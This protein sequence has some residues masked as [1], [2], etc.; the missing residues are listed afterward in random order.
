MICDYSIATLPILIGNGYLGT[1][2][3]QNTDLK[4]YA[5]F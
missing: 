4:W 3:P 2:R 5:K 1:L